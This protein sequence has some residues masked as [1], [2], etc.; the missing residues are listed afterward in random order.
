MVE[1]GKMVEWVNSWARF[2]ED[3][4]VCGEKGTGGGGQGG[5]AG[6][7]E[8]VWL[9]IRLISGFFNHPPLHIRFFSIESY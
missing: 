4:C 5:Q 8:A 7:E 1:K 9:K 6:G 2:K 3:T